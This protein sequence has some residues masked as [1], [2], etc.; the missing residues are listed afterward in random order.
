[1]GNV[2]PKPILS[3]VVNRCG[4]NRIAGGCV[5]IN[6]YR[7]TMEDSHCMVIAEDRMIFGIF[8]GHSNDKC[9]QFIAEHLPRRLSN[10]KLPISDETITRIC[11]ELDADYLE[12]TRDGGTTG[13]F[14]II[15][16]NN[17]ITI[18]NIG[19][20]RIM[21]IRNGKIHFVT[22]DHKP[23]DPREK[24]RIESCGG[25]V[26]LNRVDGDLAVSRAFGDGAFKL[27]ED[28][29]P[30]SQRVICVPEITRVQL[31]EN[32]VILLAC[33]GVFEGNFANDNVVEF[34]MSNIP[35]LGGDYGVAA[36][37]VCNQAVRKGSK[38]NISC[39]VLQ[40]TDGSSHIATHGAS[41]FIPG[42][43]YQKDH[44]ASKTAY[45]R[46]AAIGGYTLADCLKKRYELFEAYISGTL[47]N[48]MPIDQVAFDMYDEIDKHTESTF[49]GNVPTGE[50]ADRNSF[51]DCLAEGM[52]YATEK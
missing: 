38:D 26:R 42:P 2:L 44:D 3:K 23:Q 12:Q 37:Y 39:M 9:S 4:S 48:R 35:P 29:C 45:T 28:R 52:V 40:L 6:G 43:P 19:D 32:D 25:V 11:L 1:M 50:D 20:S 36:A 41:S 21:I 49:W 15:D 24:A 47:T 10:E 16:K 31:E 5:S 14:C 17:E 22:V 33:D 18:A 30:D 51:F 27:N 34:L 7:M 8:D 46:M 13:T